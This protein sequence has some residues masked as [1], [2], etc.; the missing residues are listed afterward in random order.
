MANW[1][2]R[3]RVRVSRA[4]S[5]EETEISFDFD[6]RKCRLTGGSR[7]EPL[8]EALW[9]TFLS[10]GFETKN[11]AESFGR[12]LARALRVAALDRHLG[13]DFGLDR[14]T[15]GFSERIVKAVA[16]EGG[17]LLPNVHG[18]FVYE[19]EGNE[20]FISI[21]ATGVVR[22]DPS[23]MVASLQDARAANLDWDNRLAAAI[24]LV[25]LSKMAKEPLSEAALSISALEHLAAD[26]PWSDRQLALLKSLEQ[27][28]LTSD[29][30]EDERAEVAKAVAQS[31][32]SIRQS[33]RTMLRRLRF[34][35]NDLKTFDRLYGLRSGVFHG[36]NLNRE[37]YQLLA[38][39]AREFCT[40]VVLAAIKG[41]VA[42]P[43]AD[44][45]VPAEP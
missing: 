19:K 9:W 10:D 15:I 5:T 41:S 36:S 8:S 28:A 25:L 30:E 3:L 13:V 37:Q 26:M 1:A 4:L 24:E 44:Q 45:G 18:L 29:L 27:V 7:D 33:I 42:L 43:P 6:Q 39:E 21:S 11:A 12:K 20:T 16:N 22:G 40:K 14:A 34:D 23:L 38:N 17:K 35:A 31:F 2:F 32:K